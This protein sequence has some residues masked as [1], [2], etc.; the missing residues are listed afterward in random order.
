MTDVVSVP[1]TEVAPGRIGGRMTRVEDERLVRGLGRYVDDIDPPRLAHVAFARCPY[2]CARIASIDA[3]RA[4]DLDGVLEVLLPDDVLGRTGP[5]SILRPIPDA[6]RVMPYAL[7]R[8]VALYEGQPVVSICA[9]S[10]AIAEDAVAAL[11]I[12]YEPVPHVSDVEAALEDD[13]PVLHPEL[14]TNLLVQNPRGEG[15]P[16]AG[17]ADSEVVVDDRFRINRVSGL[18][19]ETR[20][21]VATYTPGV[22]ELDVVASTQ[23]PHLFRRQLSDSLRFPEADIRVATHD[24]GGA[25]GLKLG[26][27]AEDVLVCLHALDL[28]R[29]VKWVEDRMEFFRAAT[30][31]RESLHVARMGAASDGRILA[32][33]NRYYVDLGA[34]NSPMGSPMLSSLMFQGPYAFLHGYVERNVVLTNKVPVGAYRGYGQPEGCFVRELLLDRIARRLRIDPLEIRL[35]NFIAPDQMPWQTPGGAK[36]DSGD[37][38]TCLEMA[39]EGIGYAAARERQRALR[40]EGRYTGIGVA[41]YVEMTGYPGSKFLG[42]HHAEYGAHEGVVIRANRSGGVDL[43]TGVPPIGQ[44]TETAFTQVAATVIGLDAARVRVFA[45]DTQGTP[46]NT[47][48][49]ASRTLI[50]GSGAIQRAGREIRDKALRVAAFMLEVPVDGLELV[51]SVIRVVDD[52]Q[53]SVSFEDV[54]VNAFYGHRLPE[55][56]APGLEAT[57]YY[58]PISSAFSYG[59]AAA[60]VEV[61]P[62]TGEFSLDRF[63]FVHD[64]GRQVNPMLVEGQLHGGIAQALG[65]ALFEELVYDADSG[66]LINGSMIDYFMPTTAD[67]PNIELDHTELHS[68]VT[69]MGVRGI[70]ESGT[71]PPGAAVANALCDALAPFGVDI[72]RLPLTAEYVWRLV[73]Q[74]ESRGGWSGEAR[75]RL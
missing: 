33:T 75:P 31:A 50:A 56:E 43:Y 61:D 46:V 26:I 29:P 35:R 37:Y 70:G 27:F 63:L 2:P 64:C 23:A 38:A 72:N 42:K 67:L 47:G 4:R 14:G 71:I 5:I 3:S 49:F 1:D 24:C 58:D 48:S 13:A 40:E 25:F 12:D 20:A 15:S 6:P 10:R 36:Y 7:P 69:P 59:T 51:D 39:A 16:D 34:H 55:G 28:G 62:E 18:P 11:D 17:F 74:A 54:A 21:I 68:P 60:L 22:R 41:C 66:Q 53:V 32:Y 9:T 8:E 45:G 44:S 30:Q 57:A 65:A 73:S 19:M 52:P